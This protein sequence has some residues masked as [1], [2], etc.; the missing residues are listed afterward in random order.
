M[1]MSAQPSK[2][3]GYWFIAAGVAFFFAAALGRQVA[4]AGVGAAF[5]VIGAAMVQK[6]KRSR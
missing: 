1:K 4:F 6:A 2:Q 3:S 5:V